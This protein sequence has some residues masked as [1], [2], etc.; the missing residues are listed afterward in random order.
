MKILKKLLSVFRFK[1]A[2]EVRQ[3]SREL[4]SDG[5]EIA[6][7]SDGS[8]RLVE[9]SKSPV[10][11]QYEKTGHE[12]ITGNSSVEAAQKDN[13]VEGVTFLDSPFGRRR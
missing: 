4:L 5:N 6:R 12:V 1:K 3:I 10:K 9:F 2:T 7:F 11:L 8:S 13:F